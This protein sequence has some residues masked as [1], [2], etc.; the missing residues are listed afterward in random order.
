V[1]IMKGQAMLTRISN[2]LPKI[3]TLQ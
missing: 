1:T 2:F 3:E